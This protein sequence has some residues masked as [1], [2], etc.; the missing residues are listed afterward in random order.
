MNINK[1]SKLFLRNIYLYDIKACHYTILERL[2][3]DLSNIDKNNKKNRNIQIGK[4]MKQNPRLTNIL[5]KTTNSIID[6][7]I[8]RNNITE[9]ELILRQYDGIIVTRVLH[10]TVDQSI[11]LD[12]RKHFEVF[13]ISINRNKYLAFDGIETTIKGVP[14]RY[15]Q[16]DELY[17]EIAQINFNIRSSIFKR[18]QEIKN[19]ILTSN[20]PELYCIPIDDNKYSVFLKG[21][22]ETEITNQT[23]KIM[24]VNDIDKHR[25]FNFYLRPFT[26]SITAEFI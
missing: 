8:S 15:K 21:Y 17:K 12:L 13:I 14:Y 5:R 20:N 26:E 9:D 7:N 4:L 19:R 3:F 24:D 10:E 23:V 25:Y 22:G 6:E 1:N 16:I 2:G 18:L 11:P